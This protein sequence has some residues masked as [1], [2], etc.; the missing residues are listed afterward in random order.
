MFEKSKYH[1]NAQLLIILYKI[2]KK[3]QNTIE[4]KLNLKKSK[5]LRSIK[6]LSQ[7]SINLQI[8]SINALM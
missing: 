3:P 8:C 5:I 4:I 7:I 2:F 6:I 1:K